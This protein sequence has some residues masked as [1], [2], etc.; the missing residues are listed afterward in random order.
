MPEH[1]LQ[2]F[3]RHIH[4]LPPYAPTDRPVLGLVAGTRETLLVDAGNSPAHV[5]LLL[6]GAAAAD[7]RPPT[8]LMLTHWHWDHVFG[9]GCFPIPTFAHV[10]T[11]RI[12]AEMA[13]QAWDD[14]A[15]DAR[16]AAG[17][18]IAFCRD[19]I[20]AEL[21]D[22]TGLLIRPPT[23]G[24]TA[25]V[26]LDLGGT[27]AVLQHVGGD[28]AADSSVVYM[29]DDGVVFLGDC[30]SPA[31]YGGPRRY[32]AAALL[33][34]FARVLAFDAA[35]YLAGHNP[36]P[37]SRAELATWAERVRVLAT[38]LETAGPERP[39]V[40]EAATAALGEPLTADDVEDLD[41]LL[42]GLPV[43]GRR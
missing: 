15:L 35:W 33:A 28:H 7:V 19:M 12:V 18:E 10:E 29:P 8:L 24:F 22:R 41:S 34:L 6:A 23:V 42:Q 2:P 30:L 32:T 14:A 1:T 36:D 17:T 26:V 3:T 39:A 20:R 37:L 4:W 13:G 5:R 27:T 21:P 9:T 43:A 40:L 38:A 31:I 11:R 16:V 25:T